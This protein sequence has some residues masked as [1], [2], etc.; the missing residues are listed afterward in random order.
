VLK[1]SDICAF[2]DSGAIMSI[3]E[4]KVLVA[5][6]KQTRFP[7][8][9]NPLSLYFYS[10]D[11]FLMEQ[12]PWLAYEHHLEVGIE[13]FI[14]LLKPLAQKVPKCQWFNHHKEKFK[15]AIEDIQKKIKFGELEKA[16]PFVF[17]VSKT[18]MTSAQLISSLL[19]ALEFSIHYPLHLYGF[20]EAERGLLGASPEILFSLAKTAQNTWNLNTSALAGTKEA[21][22]NDIKMEID[23]KILHEHDLVIAGIKESLISYGEVVIEKIQELRLPNLAHL[24]TPIV[25]KMNQKPDLQELIARLHPTPALGAFPRHP[26]MV[27]LQS[28]QR[29][30]DRKHFG[31]PVGYIKPQHE[32]AS[33]Y[34]AI[35]N[36]QWNASEIQIGAGCGIVAE[37]DFNN[38]WEELNLKISSVKEILAL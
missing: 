1:F 36:A 27:W 9:F 5:W 29:L 34:V 7:H 28:Y 6:G 12:N 24:K 13:E 32:V 10:S 23:P 33:F 16:V 20:W 15:S 4:K 22:R 37:S 18:P 38:E 30:I 35:R 19:K 26:G 25:V 8:P 31:A 11:F 2:I 17:E 21:E 3:P 14:P